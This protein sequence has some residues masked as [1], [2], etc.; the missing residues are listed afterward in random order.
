MQASDGFTQFIGAALSR[1]CGIVVATELH[2]GSLY[3]DCRLMADI[4]AAIEQE[5]HLLMLPTRSRHSWST[6]SLIRF[7]S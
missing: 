2:R 5:I 3:R 1:E 7:D 6:I 4:G